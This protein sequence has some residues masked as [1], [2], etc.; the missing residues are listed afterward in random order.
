M[1]PA[2]RGSAMATASTPGYPPARRRRGSGV[3]SVLTGTGMTPARSA[4]Q[5]TTGKSTV[6]SINMTMRRSRPM[7]AAASAASETPRGLGEAAL[8]SG[9][10]TDPRTPR[11]SHR[12]RSPRAG[13]R[14]SQLRFRWGRFRPVSCAS[15]PQP[16]QPTGTASIT[17]P[18][19]V[20]FRPRACAMRR[21]KQARTPFGSPVRRS[22]ARI[23]KC[24]RAIS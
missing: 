17:A 7:P 10:A 1:Q 4:P 8:R 6:S 18:A 20:C 5:N 3:N 21:S 2:S 23:V 19:A 24:T 13:R 14:T 12:R 9:S 11:Q 22:T 16:F 15:F